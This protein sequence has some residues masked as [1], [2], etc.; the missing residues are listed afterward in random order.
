MCTI[1]NYVV[2]YFILMDQ[3]FGLQKKGQKYQSQLP[4]AQD[5]IFNL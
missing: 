4:K 3:L 1:I 5:G 2:D